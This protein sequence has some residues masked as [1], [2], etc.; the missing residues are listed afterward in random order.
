VDGWETEYTIGQLERLVSGVGYEVIETYG[1]W[2]VPS[3][4]YRLLRHAAEPMTSLPLEP[5]GPE[6]VRRAR[7]SIRDRLL[8]PRVARYAAH[9]IGIVARKPNDI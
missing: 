4:A 8:T 3:L 2:M 9:T 6:A 5:R 1:D 7:S